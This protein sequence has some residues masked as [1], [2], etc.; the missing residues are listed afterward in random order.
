MGNN[1]LKKEKLKYRKNIFTLIACSLFTLSSCSNIND[2]KE[3]ITKEDAIAMANDNSY[4]DSSKYN[5]IKETSAW[6]KSEATDG[7]AK[8]AKQSYEYWQGIVIEKKEIFSFNAEFYF[9]FVCCK[10][11]IEMLSN[12]YYFYKIKNKIG[13]LWT[14]THSYTDSIEKISKN[15]NY[16]EEGYIES[17]SY[18]YT[19]TYKDGS[20]YTAVHDSNYEWIE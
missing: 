7:L 14:I 19:T 6:T 2:K 12:E 5:F 17:Y 8:F 20:S 3:E 11:V 1:L 16:N 4:F 15:Y 10:E 9:P 18:S 13:V